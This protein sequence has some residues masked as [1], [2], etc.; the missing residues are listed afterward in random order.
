MKN[1]RNMCNTCTRKLTNSKFNTN[2]EE[3]NEGMMES[4]QTQRCHKIFLILKNDEHIWVVS[5]RM[6]GFGLTL[7]R[8][9]ISIDRMG[10]CMGEQ[11]MWISR[12]RNVFPVF[13]VFYHDTEFECYSLCT[14][15]TSTKKNIAFY[16]IQ[17]NQKLYLCFKQPVVKCNTVRI[18]FRIKLILNSRM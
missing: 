9:K 17:R 7:T 3:P 15:R 11:R 4:E 14:I 5:G 6:V 16:Y 10:R 12:R 1:V 8:E 2:Q 18:E 13:L